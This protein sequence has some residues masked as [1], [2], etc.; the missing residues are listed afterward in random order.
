MRL[1]TYRHPE[2]G[3][4]ARAGVLQGDRVLD[5]GRLTGGSLGPEMRD[6][7]ADWTAAHGDLR[8]ASGA[9]QVE[10][11]NKAAVPVEIA[12]PIW[13]VT[14][15]PPVPDPPSVRDFLAFE[16]HAVNMFA[17]QDRP[18]PPVWYQQP[19]FGFGNSGGITGPDADVEK[20]ETTQE[21]DFEMELAAVIGIGGRD[22]PVDNAMSHI[23]G[24]TLLNDWTARDLQRHENSVGLGAAKGKDFALSLGPWLV[25]RDELED[26]LLDDRLQVDVVVR[27]NGEELG[28]DNAGEMHWS[29]AQMIAHASGSAE[30]RPG[31]VIGSGCM[32]NGSLLDLGTE[33]QPWL[34]SGDVVEIEAE[35]FGR[36]RNRVI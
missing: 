35:G 7:L 33:R 17:R 30:L 32:G 21:L 27:V 23:A 25:T 5:V 11:E 34:E 9:F 31:D 22:I 20:P 10:F 15:L 8:L 3:N 24:F 28:R 13:E 19:V 36:L 12:L 14:L 18:V 2:T 1:V 29:F 6:L 26:V 4:E 16:A